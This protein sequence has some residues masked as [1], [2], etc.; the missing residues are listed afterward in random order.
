MKIFKLKIDWSLR[1]LAL[2]YMLKRFDEKRQRFCPI[3]RSEVLR[4]K[5]VW[6]LL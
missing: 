1:V 4:E 6:I 2:V 5:R 3:R